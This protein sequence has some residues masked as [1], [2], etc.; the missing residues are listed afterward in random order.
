FDI[1]TDC[2]H[3]ITVPCHVYQ[4]APQDNLLFIRRENIV[5]SSFRSDPIRPIATLPRL[6]DS[7]TLQPTMIEIGLSLICI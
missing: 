7:E 6:G 5:N 4:P 1:H 3:M 2:R